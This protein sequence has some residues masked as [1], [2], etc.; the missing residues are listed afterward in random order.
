MR[1]FPSTRGVFEKE[2]NGEKVG[3]KGLQFRALLLSLSLPILLVSFL[4]RS[5]SP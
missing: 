4:S 3:Q 1:P 2:E 5:F